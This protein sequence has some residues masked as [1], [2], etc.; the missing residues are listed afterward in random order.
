MPPG[1]CYARISI[2][3]ISGESRLCGILRA[4]HSMLC[5]GLIVKKDRVL[6]IDGSTASATPV[7]GL[8]TRCVNSKRIDRE[9]GQSTVDWWQHCIWN[10]CERPVNEVCQ[11]EGNQASRP[12]L[13]SHGT[14]F[15]G[16]RLTFGHSLTVDLFAS[17]VLITILCCCFPL[18]Q[19]PLPYFPGALFRRAPH[20]FV[21]WF[22]PLLPYAAGL[23]GY[24]RCALYP[25]VFPRDLDAGGER[26]IR[27]SSVLYM[28]LLFFR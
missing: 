12:R 5:K 21:W 13:R 16:L 28:Y 23:H 22:F 25:C 24:S 6:W 1:V 10:S 2:I 14:H 9:K 26:C 8:L 27:N 20:S 3:P 17:E 7:S 15:G 18:G 19:F 4:E 11:L